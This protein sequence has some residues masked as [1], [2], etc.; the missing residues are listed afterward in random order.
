MCMNHTGVLLESKPEEG[1]VLVADGVEHGGDH[2]LHEAVLLVVV[3]VN[4]ALPV[5][6]HL[7]QAV[8]LAHIAQV[9]DILLEA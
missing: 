5:V 7:G 6:S 1:D 4:N 3:H 9:E 8:C 2:A